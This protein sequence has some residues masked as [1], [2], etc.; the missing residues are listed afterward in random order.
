MNF[1]STLDPVIQNQLLQEQY[2]SLSQQLP[3]QHAAE[4]RNSIR[5]HAHSAEMQ[6]EDLEKMISQQN[7]IMVNLMAMMQQEKQRDFEKQA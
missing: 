3:N 7:Q 1:R 4:N 2:N 5:G 6:A